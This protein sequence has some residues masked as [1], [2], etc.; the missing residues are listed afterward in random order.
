MQTRSSPPPSKPVSEVWRPELTRLPVLTPG[1]RIFRWLFR[2]ICRFLICLWT[3]P[4]VQ[5]LENFPSRGPALIVINHLG[6]ADGVLALAYWPQVPESIAKIELYDFPILGWLMEALGVIWVHR[7]RPDVNA[8]NVAL[9]A[10]RQG[11]VVALAPEGRESLVGALEEG[12][13]GAAFLALKA[14]VPVIPVTVTGTENWRIYGNIKA[15]RRTPVT[16]IIGE[17][18]SLPVLPNRRQSIKAGT[19]ELMERLARQL[20]PAYRGFYAYVDAPGES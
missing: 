1:R 9:E 13:D 4:S 6:D 15:L 17:P 7:G 3:K 20:P 14:S 19:R 16:M 2:G 11:R 18:F 8:V 12:T 5:G 10:F